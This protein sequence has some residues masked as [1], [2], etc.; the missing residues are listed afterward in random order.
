ME[1]DKILTPEDVRLA[2]LLMSDEEVHDA[3]MKLAAALDSPIWGNAT[4][5][6]RELVNRLKLRNRGTQ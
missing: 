3:A 4:A 2:Y 6:I 5:C 1:S